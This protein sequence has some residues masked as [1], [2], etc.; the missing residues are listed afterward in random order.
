MD[1][2]SGIR[3]LGPAT[4]WLR[5]W[6]WHSELAPSAT[7]AEFMDVQALACPVL[8]HHVSLFLPPFDVFKLVR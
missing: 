8:T 1:E 6:P 2:L 7:A 3:R 4:W 5:G